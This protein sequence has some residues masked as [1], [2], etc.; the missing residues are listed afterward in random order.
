MWYVYYR[1]DF[2]ESSLKSNLF[3]AMHA[4]ISFKRCKENTGG[5]AVSR[6]RSTDNRRSEFPI[7]TD[8]ITDT[9]NG[10]QRNKNPNRKI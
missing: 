1:F 2:E 5:G 8:L 7:F 4:S 9:Y 10:L 3:Y 6:R